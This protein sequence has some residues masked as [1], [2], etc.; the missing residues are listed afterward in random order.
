MQKHCCLIIRSTTESISRSKE[1]LKKSR[2]TVAVNMLNKNALDLGNFLIFGQRV[3]LDLGN[4]LTYCQ[5]VA[6]DLG[7][8]LTLGQ[9]VTLDLGYFLTFC[10]RV[11]LDLGNFDREGSEIS[12]SLPPWIYA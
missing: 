11:A 6:L 10:Q 2:D 1:C 9:R 8:F 7:N 5:R 12:L 4:F 3:T